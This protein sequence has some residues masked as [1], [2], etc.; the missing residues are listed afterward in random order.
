MRKKSKSKI[1]SAF[2]FA[3][4]ARL[5]SKADAVRAWVGNNFDALID[6]FVKAGVARGAVNENGV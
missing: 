6:Q 2:A 1:V 4:F 5:L 3:H